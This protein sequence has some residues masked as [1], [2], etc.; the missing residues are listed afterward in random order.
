MVQLYIGYECT[1]CSDLQFPVVKK[2]SLWYSILA[3]STSVF[4]EEGNFDS[5]LGY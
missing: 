3:V 1:R 4:E 2:L 5:S